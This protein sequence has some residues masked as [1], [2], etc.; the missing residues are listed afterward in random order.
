MRYRCEE[1]GLVQVRGFFPAET[2]HLRYAVFHGLAIGV[3]SV[4]VKIAF[5]RMGYVPT[6]W[7]GG[8]FT[9]GA[10]AV[11]LLVIYGIAVVIEQVTV[12]ARGCAECRSR[13]VVSAS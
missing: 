7:R 6:G 3:S 4:A 9:L 5:A 12:A 8:L 10:C 13:R 1:C 2:F 11:L